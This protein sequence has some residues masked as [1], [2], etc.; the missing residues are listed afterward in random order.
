MVLVF[1][2][3]FSVMKTLN[4]HMFFFHTLFFSSKRVVSI[5]SDIEFNNVSM[6]NVKR[7]VMR[8]DGR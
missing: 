1:L 7:L 4:V 6:E 8:F 2:V 3:V 5:V